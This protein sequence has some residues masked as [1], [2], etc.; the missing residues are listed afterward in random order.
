MAKRYLD[1]PLS[2]LTT[3]TRCKNKS[4]D[5]HFEFDGCCL[6][7]R[8]KIVNT[9]FSG[10]MSPPGPS[11]EAPPPSYSTAYSQPP[12]ASYPQPPMGYS[13]PPPNYPQPPTAQLP[14]QYPQQY[15]QQ[16]PQ[17]YPQQYPPQ[18]Y[19]DPATVQFPQSQYPG[20]QNPSRIQICAP[21]PGA[22]SA[23]RNMEG[24]TDPDKVGRPW[25][26][27]YD[28]AVSY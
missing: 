15:P 24:E 20:P 7:L 3:A 11:E 28:P 10:R 9:F 2:P 17:Q 19:P 27:Y 8:V 26:P 14:Q 6:I 4:Y 25:N 21:Y 16:L 5:G 18:G 1:P 23:P 13:Q 22:S 12:S